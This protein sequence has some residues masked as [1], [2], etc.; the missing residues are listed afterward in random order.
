MPG[1]DRVHV[2]GKFIYL[3]LI[4]FIFSLFRL[5]QPNSP[6]SHLLFIGYL[7]LTLW[8]WLGDARAK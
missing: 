2:Q 6:K 4:R 1:L 5:H 7:Q 3:S 8:K